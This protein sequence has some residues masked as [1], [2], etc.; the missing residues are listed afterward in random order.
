MTRAHPS[1]V[2]LRSSSVAELANLS[3]KQLVELWLKHVGRPPPNATST[4]LLLRAAAYRVQEQ[5]FGGLKRQDLR[6]LHKASD[7][8]KVSGNKALREAKALSET[9][10]KASP[11]LRPNTGLDHA[12]NARSVPAQRGKLW[13]TAQPVALRPGTRL[14][15][16]WQGK[17]HSVEVRADGFG[18]NAEVYRSLTAVAFA[19]TGARWSGNR[20][21]RL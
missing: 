11:P 8:R 5:Q 20:F 1:K 18:W 17:S 15:R 13:V 2:P 3:R 16:E 12:Q 10:G 6:L 7:P 14:V 19:I 21:F 9:A 4:S